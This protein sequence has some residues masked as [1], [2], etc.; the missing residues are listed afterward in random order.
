LALLGACNRYE[1]NQTH[2]F[3]GGQWRYAD[4]VVFRWNNTDTA[5]ARALGLHLSITDEFPFSNLYLQFAL[6]SPSGRRYQVQNQFLLAD[7]LGNW[8]ATRSLGGHYDFNT[9]LNPAARFNER[10]TYTFTLRQYMRRD[11]LLGVR[12]IGLQLAAAP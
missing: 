12:A 2:R 6:T 11:T 8:D 4:S 10:G 7:S 9:T 5:A 1:M 3:D